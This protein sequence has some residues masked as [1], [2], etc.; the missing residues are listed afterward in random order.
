MRHLL[1]LLAVA[2]VAAGCA[3]AVDR[4]DP[5]QKN[6]TTTFQE[7][8]PYSDRIDIKTDAVMVY[9]IGGC[10]ERLAKWKERGY[11][12]HLMTGVAW[13]DY[14]DFLFG[15]WD[16]VNHED[17]GQKD[18]N[19]NEINHGPTVPYM[20]PVRSYGKYLCEG[21]KKAIDAGAEAIFLEEPEFWTRAGYSEAFKREWQDYYHEP[22]QA[23]HTSPDAMY[24]SSKLKYYLYRRELNEVFS[25]IRDYSKTIKRDVKCYVA[26]H[27]MI[28][29]A[30]WGIVSPEA[31]LVQIEGCDGYIGQVWTGT[32][33]TA[34]VYN[35]VQKERTF[36]S[37][38]CEYGVLDNLIRS[39]GKRMYYL[40]DPVEDNPD[41]CWEDYKKNYESTLVASLLWTD[42]YHYEVMPWA[43]RVFTGSYPARNLNSLGPGKNASDIPRE[44]IPET[45]AAELMAISMELN[46][47]NQKSIEWDCG[48]REL[49]ILVSDT[50]MFQRMDPSPSDS[51]F[52]SF[53]GMAMPLIKRGMPVAPVQLENVNI[54]D[55]LKP[56]KVLFVTYEGMKPPRE[57]IHT[58]LADWVKDGGVLVFVDDDRDPYNKVKEWWNSDGKSYSC[59]RKH[60]FE[61]LGANDTK[62]AQKIGKGTLIYSKESPAALSHAKDGGETFAKIAREAVLAADMDWNETNYFLLHRGP[63]VIAAGL[64]ETELTGVR[65][66][67]GRF[68]NIFDPLLTVMNSVQLT[69]GSRYLLKDLGKLDK[70][71]ACVL[72]SS[73]KIAKE[74]AMTDR[75]TFTTEGPAG[76]T[77]ATRL[78]LPKKPIRLE[79][80]NVE[81]LRAEWDAINSTYLLVYPNDVNPRTVSVFW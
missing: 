62:G 55:Y 16:G 68:V 80:D 71:K 10:E 25:F 75:I 39:T 31:S 6:E 12:T 33:R 8:S 43:S 61:A 57:D 50:M 5:D 59:P 23:Q 15:Q 45:Y 70:T 3:G 24:R 74:R 46:K 64:D 34:N 27:S 21:V 4:H 69:P 28:N 67:T 29:Y 2:L 14:Q 78:L 22:W 1:C 56:Y 52:G 41:Y 36:E 53:F 26:T 66:L 30:W 42:V 63:Y 81:V 58:A 47:M 9:G 51:A 77:C 44:T 11:I 40:N 38:F 13:G 17:A 37:A 72:A 18:R 60:L 65:T 32:S 19:G 20:V 76:T 48:T 35:G 73:S 54:K 7:A 79:A 49:G